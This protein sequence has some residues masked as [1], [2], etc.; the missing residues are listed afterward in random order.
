MRK[1]IGKSTFFA[2]SLQLL[3]VKVAIPL[4][5]TYCNGN[6]EMAQP[7]GDVRTDNAKAG[8]SEPAA[9]NPLYVQIAD[10]FPIQFK[11]F[12]Q[13]GSINENPPKASG[14]PGISLYESKRN[15]IP[16]AETNAQPAH[17]FMKERS[18][19]L[20]RNSTIRCHDGNSNQNGFRLNDFSG[21][22]RF[23][24]KSGAK[25]DIFEN[26]QNPNRSRKN[27]LTDAQY[28]E[29]V[30]WLNKAK[31]ADTNASEKPLT[32]GSK[33][34]PLPELKVEPKVEPKT[35]A[36]TEAKVDPKLEPKSEQ[37]KDTVPPKADAAKIEE[38]K[39]K[40][41]KA[42]EKKVEE[43]K[44]EVPKVE[45]KPLTAFEQTIK[46]SGA[47][48]VENISAAYSA[49]GKEKD[50]V[51]L[52]IVG[53]NTPGSKE[54]LEKLPQLQAQHPEL[55]FVV[56][57]K[58]KLDERLSKNPEDSQAK[59]WKAW[60]N[61]NLKDCSGQPIDHTFTSVQTLKADA[62]G[63][64]VPEKVTSTHWGANIEASLADQSKFAA[65]GTAKNAGD[66]K[67]EAP[68]AEESIKPISVFRPKNPAE[69]VEFIQATKPELYG[70]ETAESLRER[71]AK[72]L[73]AI[74][75]ADKVN[76]EYLSKQKLKLQAEIEKENVAA[77]TAA[78]EASPSD[79]PADTSKIDGLN[80]QLRDLEYLEKAPGLLRTEMGAD[81]LYR[82][83]NEKNV[84]KQAAM[85]TLAED[86]LRN[87]FKADP[88]LAKDD[89]VDLHLFNLKAD[90]AKLAQEAGASNLLSAD[91][92][93]QRLKT[94]AKIG[95][96]VPAEK[97][98]SS[99]APFTTTLSK[100][101]VRLSDLPGQPVREL[102]KATSGPK[103]ER[104]VSNT[105][106]GEVRACNAA[107]Q[108]NCQSF[109]QSASQNNNCHSRRPIL[110]FLRRRR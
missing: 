72:Y 43:K 8:T 12:N 59:E 64:P 11:T 6:K 4:L 27:D 3:P 24:P 35:E 17:D 73:Q 96:I 46:N 102:P 53:E 62:S 48:T 97:A 101:A 68:K 5:H 79:K 104:S 89:T 80:K 51:A 76:P 71:Q 87:A 103:I 109:C 66:F 56:V 42:E 16:A 40:E 49:A 77:K 44:V 23:D 67:F 1:E 15:E 55:T 32:E 38:N 91:Q 21:L 92:I 54:L 22:E 45:E 60:V 61:Q 33:V 50:G 39:T 57:N 25:R 13:S 9:V 14:L 100:E 18:L 83:S 93:N 26:L 20:N 58:D 70:K 37:A 105:C 78:Y 28:K 63:K 7:P 81:L 90:T 75:V 86:I 106:S 82:A 74:A 99:E 31:K 94:I 84:E 110:N 108:S 69:A 19:F 29:L 41:N 34:T 95:V 10:D 65:D 107:R 85:K 36:K 2:T 47:Y 30:E 52:V 88:A 98:T